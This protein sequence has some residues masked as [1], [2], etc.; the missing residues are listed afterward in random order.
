[1]QF[2]RWTRVHAQILRETF[3]DA[4]RARG[5]ALV[6]VLSEFVIEYSDELRR[7][8]AAAEGAA[9]LQAPVLTPEHAARLIAR[10]YALDA[11]LLLRLYQQRWSRLQS[12]KRVQALCAEIAR[13]RFVGRLVRAAGF[14]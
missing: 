5:T 7:V 14:S 2:Y 1:L 3:A 6:G 4:D 9:P 11:S 13:H 8:V 12:S 10:L